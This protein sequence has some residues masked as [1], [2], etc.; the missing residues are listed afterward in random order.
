[1]LGR[2]L[3]INSTLILELRS[4]F[5]FSDHLFSHHVVGYHVPVEFSPSLMQRNRENASNLTEESLASHNRRHDSR[6]D[7]HKKAAEKETMK[8]FRE[9]HDRYRRFLVT[10]DSA[11][12]PEVTND[13]YSP[14]KSTSESVKMHLVRV[15]N[16]FHIGNPKL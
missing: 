4:R 12:R 5:N 16:V 10:G 2:H 3:S 15:P 13:Q 8:G 11:R 7:S 9:E 1:M 6:Q 14:N